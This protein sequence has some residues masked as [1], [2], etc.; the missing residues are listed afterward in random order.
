[1]L[2]LLIA[3]GG[4]FVTDRRTFVGLVAAS[5]LAPSLT[6]EAQ[7]PA[8]L[9][10]IGFLAFSSP[11]L[12]EVQLDA[13]REGLRNLGYVDGRNI[14]IE[15]R[16]AEG[17]VERLSGLARELIGLG[18]DLIL[19][20][21]SL[22]ALAAKSATKTIP[23]VF[24]TAGDP[25]V[26]VSSIARPGGNITGLSLVAPEIVAKQLEYLK[27]VVPDASRVAV[28]SNPANPITD[29]MVKEV[30][31]AARAMHLRIQLLGVSDHHAF[32][33]ALAAIVNERPDAL[34]VLF[35]PLLLNHRA[36]ITAF[37]NNNH[38]PAMYPHREYVQPGGLM[39]YGASVADMF[40]RSAAYVVTILKGAKPA[41]LPV[42]QPTTYELVVSLK[43]AKTLGL[44]IPQTL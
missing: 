15:Y 7:R 16:W 43:A 27:G 29:H 19:A 44:T 3:F 6:V 40:R 5:L 26:L 42:E 23:I 11:D 41:D 22:A 36:R 17:R 35:D 9:P 38:L 13:F 24:A 39:S 20:T 30:E 28:L 2:A 10:R 18:V 4:S 31:A 33:N 12:T 34:L 37:A 25:T 1:M 32:E 8:K 21:N 14:S